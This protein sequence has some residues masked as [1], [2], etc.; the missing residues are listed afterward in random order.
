MKSI[1]ALTI[2]GTGFVIA[3]AATVNAKLAPY[4]ETEKP[5]VVQEAALTG[6]PL[7]AMLESSYFQAPRGTY[8]DRRYPCRLQMRMFEKT[9]LAQSC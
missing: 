2:L 4:T 7:G 1:V 6:E 3:S 8:A 9:Q 5:Q